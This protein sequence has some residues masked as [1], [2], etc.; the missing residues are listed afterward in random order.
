[1]S[2]VRSERGR[3]RETY[4]GFAKGMPR[5]LWV[6]PSLTPANVPSSKAI[7]GA[8]L[9]TSWD[10]LE[11]TVEAIDRNDSAIVIR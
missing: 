7:V 6:V 5:N 3:V 11:E 1:M 2:W 8:E 9:K 4:G 10:E